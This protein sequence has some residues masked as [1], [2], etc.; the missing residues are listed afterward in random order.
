MLPAM[1]PVVPPLPICSVPAADRRAAG[2]GVGAGQDER[3]G[4]G[5]GHRAGA[6]DHAGIGER[7]AAVEDERAVVDDVAGDAAGG[8]AVAELQ[9]AGADRRR[10][11]VG[12]GAGQRQRAGAGLGERAGAADHAAD[13]S[14]ASLRLKMTVALSTMLPDDAAGRAAIAELQRAG[15]DRRGAGVGV[16]GG[17]RQRA[18][19]ALGERA[20]AAD[21]AVEVSAC[22]CG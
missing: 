20:G 14:S 8:A 9:R 6:A 5:L 18:G 7:V 19:A 11:G 16:V 1:L 21:R 22:P 17:Q 13:R 3:A 4:A 12:V 15:A 10:A 2:I